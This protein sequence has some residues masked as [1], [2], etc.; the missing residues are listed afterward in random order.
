MLIWIRKWIKTTEPGIRRMRDKIV[1]GQVI[2]A[3]ID[4]EIPQ[5]LTRKA[6]APLDANETQNNLAPRAESLKEH[7]RAPNT[8]ALA[9]E[10]GIGRL[11]ER[12][13]LNLAP[14]YDPGAVSKP[15]ELAF[16]ETSSWEMVQ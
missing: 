7:S 9:L 11:A 3:D 15:A 12:K 5:N 1:C 13:S 16:V 2:T 6:V 14:G 4:A 10:G 8:H